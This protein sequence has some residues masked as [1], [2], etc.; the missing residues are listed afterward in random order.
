MLARLLIFHIEKAAG[1]VRVIGLL[2]LHEGLGLEVGRVGIFGRLRLHELGDGVTAAG[3]L[4]HHLPIPQESRRARQSRGAC[5]FKTFAVIS[6]LQHG[7]TRQAHSCADRRMESG[8]VSGLALGQLGLDLRHL[9][10][11]QLVKQHHRHRQEG[12]ERRDERHQHQDAR[13]RLRRFGRRWP[14]NP[15]P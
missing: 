12:K 4:D 11:V 3:D 14:R 2:R 15:A 10:I 9:A 13:L 6:G 7:L 8:F 1:V 5:Q